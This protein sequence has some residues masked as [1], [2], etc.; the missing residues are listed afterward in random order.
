MTGTLVNVAGIAL[1][2]LVGLLL[3]KGIPEHINN[4]IVRALGLG[5]IIIGL[6]GIIKSMLS[7]DLETGALSDSGSLLLVISLAV[8]C[9]A[10][11]LLRIDDHLNNFGKMMENRL[12]ASGFAKG[13]VTAS[14]L[15]PIG[16]M[17]VIGALNDGLF[18]DSQVL[19]VKSLLDTVMSVVLSSALG[20]GVLFSA[21]PV[22]L[23]QGSISL[24][25]GVLAPHITQ[26]LLNVFCM[27]GYTLVTVIGLNLTLDAKIKVAN[28][29]PA[30]V[31]PIFYHFL[32][33]A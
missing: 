7:V 2:S 11:E 16:A 6:L 31:V 23:I 3:K 1:G 26:E 17:T 33:V 5:T 12:G 9:V 22:L 21:V 20:I 24:L 30:L 14:L 27:V 10:G 19:Y 13:F 15:F 25:A 28:L 4:A 29:L 8:G 32:F 18:G